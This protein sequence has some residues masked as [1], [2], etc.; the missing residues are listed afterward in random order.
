MLYDIT[1]FICSFIYLLIYAFIFIY[2]IA[3][4]LIYFIL[5]LSLYLSNPI[6][7]LSIFCRI[8]F[9]EFLCILYWRDIMSNSTESPFVVECNCSLT[10]EMTTLDTKDIQKQTESVM[11]QFQRK[12]YFYLFVAVVCHVPWV[13]LV[14]LVRG[15]IAYS[16]SN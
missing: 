1:L 3:Y 4:L 16:Q 10:G 15:T 6:I 9:C 11:K 7:A 13:L 2:L 5:V 12:G 8:C 14:V